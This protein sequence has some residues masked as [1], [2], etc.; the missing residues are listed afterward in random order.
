MPKGSECGDGPARP[1]RPPLPWSAS[2]GNPTPAGRPSPGRL[3]GPSELAAKY[4]PHTLGPRMDLL[5]WPPHLTHGPDPSP[6]RVALPGRRRQGGLE[7]Q[8][9]HERAQ[10]LGSANC[11][12]TARALP[13]QPTYGETSLP[14]GLERGKGKARA[15]T[16]TPAAKDWPAP[17]LHY[18]STWQRRT[19]G[20]GG[21]G[22]LDRADECRFG[23]G[24]R[25]RHEGAEGGGAAPSVQSTPPPFSAAPNRMDSSV[26]Y[27]GTA[28]HFREWRGMARSPRPALQ[29]PARPCKALLS[30]KVAN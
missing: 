8:C 26:Y 12:P 27:R 1:P 13:E 5:K 11:R 18:Q 16:A 23:K 2:V 10:G 28:T 30:L 20:V 9:G 25:S 14:M 24:C 3:S 15:D 22:R 19:G 7:S 29:G 6:A 4:T 21:G 17:D